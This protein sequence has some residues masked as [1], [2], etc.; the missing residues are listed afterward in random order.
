[1]RKRENLLVFWTLG[2]MI[3]FA[4]CA[5]ASG[6]ISG[7]TSGT[8][9]ETGT[10]AAKAEKDKA[11][12]TLSAEAKKSVAG[13]TEFACDLYKRLAS[14]RTGSN[15]FISPYGISTALALVY[16]GARHATETQMAGVLHF[17]LPQ[18]KIHPA[19]RELRVWLD[20]GGSIYDNTNLFQLTVANALWLQKG[21]QLT[22]SFQKTLTNY[23]QALQTVDFKG[24]AEDSRKTINAWVSG[25]TQGQIAEMAGP[26][27]V[28]SE[29]RMVIT[30][31]VFFKALWEYRFTKSETQD[32]PFTIA[33]ATSP[34]G[35]PTTVS[36]PM[37]R[38]TETLSYYEDESLQAIEL[39]YNG[40]QGSFFLLLPKP[41]VELSAVEQSLSTKKLY[42]WHS[43]MKGQ[44]VHL[45]LPRFKISNSIGLAK[46]LTSMGMT[47]AFSSA[48]DF[49]G[50]LD[51]KVALQDV[52]H[53]AF[54]EFDEEGTVP[55][56]II[57]ASFFGVM[58]GKP[59]NA[60]FR[61]DHPF[62]FAI[63]H[64]RT[65]SLLF[66]GRVMNPRE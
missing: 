38:L 35:Q 27:Q 39:P 44:K 21:F 30:N 12:P 2:M 28:N 58:A 63:Y 51:D 43:G 60:T 17:D 25:Q 55:E 61:A 14:S 49:S 32:E 46:T 19:F 10:S 56:G 11:A 66:L 5:Y 6:L 16:G 59:Q 4:N 20:K 53:K 18:E 22:P 3:L 15:I 41:G 33:A 65:G 47:D 36:V 52:V 42:A 40:L 26:G 48:A 50:L 31:A 1:M 45:F 23:P 57:D 7:S 64:N 37:M 34:S 24:A 29:S 62:L 13:N 54:V 9:A 8:P